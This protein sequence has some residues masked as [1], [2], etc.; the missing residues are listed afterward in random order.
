VIF[1][2][3]H[4]VDSRLKAVGALWSGQ[5][6]PQIQGLET[7]PIDAVFDLASLTKIFFGALMLHRWRRSVSVDELGCVGDWVD[8]ADPFSSLSGLKVRDLAEHRSG[9]EAHQLLSPSRLYRTNYRW[10][11]WNGD[12]ILHFLAKQPR[13]VPGE[14]LY[15]DLGFWFL[16]WFLNRVLP[17]GLE[18]QWKQLRSEILES[19]SAEFAEGAELGF[20]HEIGSTTDFVAT[21]SRH[22]PAEVNDDNAAWMGGI[23]GHAGLF[24]NLRGVACVLSWLRKHSDE[25]RR[26]QA[27]SD[28]RFW[29][30]WDTPTGPDSMAGSNAPAQAIGH[31]GFTG[32]SFWW[33]PQSGTGSVLLTNRVYP[34]PSQRSLEW[35]RSF[36]RAFHSEAWAKSPKRQAFDDAIARWPIDTAF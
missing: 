14:T 4:P 12:E 22:Q 36:R 27:K 29:W 26:E 31:L 30:G 24:A 8:L 16:T 10:S 28:S 20:S 33:D 23:S 7:G 32:T 19:L 6:A 34:Q 21:E 5:E 35:I 13:Q 17:G 2:A 9:W 15:S 11:Y 25:F 18:T 1:S 3:E